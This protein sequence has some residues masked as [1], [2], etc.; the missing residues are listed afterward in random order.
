M[1]ICVSSK[2]L[3]LNCQRQTVWLAGTRSKI[4]RVT[5]VDRRTRQNTVA[6]WYEI[7]KVG[8]L[9]RATDGEISFTYEPAWLASEATFPI[10][11]ALPLSKASWQGDPVVG[12]FDNLLS[13]GR[14]AGLPKGRGLELLQDMTDW[15][16]PAL[17]RALL[18]VG[19]QVPRMVSGPIATDA[20]QRAAQIKE[21]L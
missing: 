2:R 10:A 15:L 3:A 9:T 5:R 20:M 4:A 1:S 8:T 13:E 12:A 19:D 7:A 16:G 6:V 18:A 14:A 21:Q 17:D 11:I